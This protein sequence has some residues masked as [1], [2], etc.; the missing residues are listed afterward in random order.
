MKVHIIL[1]L[2][3][4]GLTLQFCTQPSELS[5]PVKVT[6]T[7]KIKAR[8]YPQ[9]YYFSIGENGVETSDYTNINKEQH[10]EAKK[11]EISV[12]TLS[13]TPYIWFKLNLE[14]KGVEQREK[15]FRRLFIKNFN[16]NIDSFPVIG[17]PL[18]LS[19]KEFPKSWIKLTLARGPKK[20]TG[21]YNRIHLLIQTN[22]EIGFTLNK[23]YR[24]IWATGYGKIFNTRF[25]LIKRD[26]TV[27]DSVLKTRWDTVWVD[28][29]PH[30]RRVDYWEK[31]EIKLQIEEI[32]SFPD[33]LI[34]NFKFRLKY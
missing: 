28:N 30:I 29:K 15:E 1:L 23:P 31:K 21:Y 25:A 13:Q 33:S 12:D 9:I 5:D 7:D 24:E 2:V 14:R 8:I 27:V 11:T 3:I 20:G 16:F 19:S 10:F 26:T 6:P 32:T 18:K 17:V 4:L 34:L 22:F